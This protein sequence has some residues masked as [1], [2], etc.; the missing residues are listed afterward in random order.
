MNMN[1]RYMNCDIKLDDC[2]GQFRMLKKEK[3]FETVSRRSQKNT[4][5]KAKKSIAGRVYKNWA[6]FTLPVSDYRWNRDVCWA[7]MNV[8]RCKSQRALTE[9][10]PHSLTSSGAEN[11]LSKSNESA[12][13]K[14][15][16]EGERSGT[17]RPLEYTSLYPNYS[18]SIPPLMYAILVIV[19]YSRVGILSIIHLTNIIN[20]C[21]NE[22]NI[23]K[24]SRGRDTI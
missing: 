16:A 18:T 9:C 20:V 5:N 1:S 11:V 2:G 23:W 24:S 22:D 10:R 17:N 13:M 8:D 12:K 6:I 7:R 15:C 14:L 4:A 3:I 19:A 21:N